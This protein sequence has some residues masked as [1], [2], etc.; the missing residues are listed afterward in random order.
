[1]HSGGSDLDTKKDILLVD[2]C[3]QEISHAK[4][5]L[6]DTLLT[7]LSIQGIARPV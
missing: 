2:S 6:G 7:D 3:I 1:M 4:Y 5:I